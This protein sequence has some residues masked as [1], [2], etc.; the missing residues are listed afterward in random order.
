MS[1]EPKV[2][3]R[4]NYSD[5]VHTARLYTEKHAA[6]GLVYVEMSESDWRDYVSFMDECREWDQ[7]LVTLDNEKY[8]KEHP[9]DEEKN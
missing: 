2:K 1:D 4:V 6:A 5:G 7:Y 3:V 9:D 8:D